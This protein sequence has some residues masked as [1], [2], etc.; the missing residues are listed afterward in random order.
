M[1]PPQD[2]DGLTLRRQVMEL[3]EDVLNDPDPDRDWA[4]AQLR[5]FLAAYPGNPERALLEHLVATRNQTDF[6]E[7][8]TAP[9]EKGAG[10]ETSVSVP[11][12]PRPVPFERRTKKRI[13][14]VLGNRM[15][16]TAFQ[17]IRELPVGRVTGFEALTRFVS[18][19]GASADTWFREAAAIGL[20]TELELAALQCALSAAREIPPHLFIA[21]NLSPTTFV[22]APIRE[23][24]EHSQVAVDRIVVDL[25][26]PAGTGDWEAAA[27]ALDRLR[28]RGL[29]IAVDGSGS[30]APTPAQILSLRPDIIRLDR[31][32]ITAITAS[33]SGDSH[34][35]VSL[36]LEV[37][38]V[39]AAE[40]VETE[41]ELAAVVE[42]GLTEGQGYLLGR[43]SVHPLDWSAWIIQAET[44]A[45][46][47]GPKTQAF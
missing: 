43:P 38:A 29:R 19:D 15:L 33:P 34:D 42:A 24:L 17:P 23:L 26:G 27:R 28:R 8:N 4:R 46:S 18:K 44:A 45:T 30:D 25:T 32:F 12:G 9:S 6:A 31:P 16:L 20:G 22:H 35:V 37:G 2:V 40:G 10:R 39:L 5:D 41:A 21:F 36:A 3:I 14:A 11:A 7:E 1:Q 13:Q 47:T